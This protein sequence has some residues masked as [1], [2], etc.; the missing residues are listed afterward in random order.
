MYF[1][2]WISVCQYGEAAIFP[3]W[4]MEILQPKKAQ[5]AFSYIKTAI[6]K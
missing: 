1:P 2:K 5:E 6:Q 3:L 4:P